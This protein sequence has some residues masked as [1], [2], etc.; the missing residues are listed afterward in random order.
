MGNISKNKEPKKFIES[1]KFNHKREYYWLIIAQAYFQCALMAARILKV[2]VDFNINENSPLKKIYGD[3]SQSPEYLILPII[4]NFKHGI[5]IYLKAIGG[6][7]NSEFNKEH[8]LCGLAG[9][10][11]IKDKDIR[12]IIRKYVKANLLLQV[13]NKYDTENQFERYPQGSPYDNVEITEI[14]NEEKI[15]ELIND[16]LFVYKKMRRVSLNL[17]LNKNK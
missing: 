13:N 12:K 3:Y 15:T 6:V 16:I 17:D 7:K 11:G 2:K 5:E 4:F 14:V 8:D 10:A 9:L 1:M